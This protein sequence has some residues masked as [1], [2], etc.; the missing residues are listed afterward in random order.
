MSAKY[1]IIETP[2]DKPRVPRC[3]LGP[4]PSRKVAKAEAARQ[5]I[6]DYQIIT[7][8]RRAA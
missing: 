8:R 1:L 2:S 6:A 4:W 7:I 5:G 3:D